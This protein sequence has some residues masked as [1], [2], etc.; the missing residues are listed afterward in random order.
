MDNTGGQGSEKDGMRG[1]NVLTF[2]HLEGGQQRGNRDRPV[3][4][5]HGSVQRKDTGWYYG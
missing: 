2:F 5:V 1:G 3:S 4:N